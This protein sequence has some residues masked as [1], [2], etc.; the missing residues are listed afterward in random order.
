MSEFL[1]AASR[2]R[3]IFEDPA[4]A[5]LFTEYEGECGNPLIGRCA[6]QLEFYER[7][8]SLDAARCFA[9]YSGRNLVG[10]AFVVVSKVPHYD[11]KLA[12]VESLF[13]SRKARRFGLG[14][15]LMEMVTEE[16]RKAGCTSLLCSAPLNSRLARLLFLSADLYAHVGHTFCR[17]LL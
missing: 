6:P 1:L 11:L 4:R 10:F 16:S 7:L 17:R 2:A 3:T 14:I 12:C 5:A 15:E 8:E 13:V 9:V